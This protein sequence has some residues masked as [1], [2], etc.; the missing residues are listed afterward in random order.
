MLDQFETD[1]VMRLVSIVGYNFTN[2]KSTVVFQNDI[3]IRRSIE[4]CVIVFIEYIYFRLLM[5][6][7]YSLEKERVFR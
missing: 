6:S 4:R 7:F 3:N 5:K 2:I 1:M